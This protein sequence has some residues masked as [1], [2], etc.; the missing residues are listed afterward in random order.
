MSVIFWD[1][2]EEEEETKITNNIS[3]SDNDTFFSSW[4]R[5]K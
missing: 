5:G 1:M 4:G 2:E 3:F